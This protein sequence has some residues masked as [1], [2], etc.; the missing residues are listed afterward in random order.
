[1]G[2]R[3]LFAGAAETIFAAAGDVPVAMYYYQHGSA[4]YDVS[5]GT[6]S[7]GVS[8]TVTTMIF[9][10]FKQTNKPNDNVD[11]TD[12]QS[13]FPQSYLPGITP[14]VKDHLQVVEAGASVRYDIVDKEQDPAGATWV[15]QLRKP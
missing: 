11:P 15:L 8:L 10:K 1:M 13:T 9:E 12:M 14:S 4:V 2:L 5:S 3:A 7:A 6:V